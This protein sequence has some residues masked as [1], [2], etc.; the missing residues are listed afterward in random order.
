MGFDHF[1]EEEL[2]R[3]RRNAVTTNRL[4]RQLQRDLRFY[5]VDAV[6]LVLGELDDDVYA[7]EHGEDFTFWR[8]I[9]RVVAWRVVLW[10]PNVAETRGV[11]IFSIANVP[12]GNAMRLLDG[13][14][15]ERLARSLDLIGRSRRDRR[16][17]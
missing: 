11:T 5:D 7:T 16:R 15:R 13:E 2:E 3:G 4:R 1:T 10:T 12:A 8:L 14:E 17:W 9:R 6:G